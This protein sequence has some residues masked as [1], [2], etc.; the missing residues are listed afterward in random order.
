MFS[1][2]IFFGALVVALETPMNH[3]STNVPSKSTILAKKIFAEHLTQADYENVINYS[4]LPADEK[5][6][7]RQ[8]HEIVIQICAYNADKAKSHPSLPIDKC[9]DDNLMDFI[10]EEEIEQL[11]KSIM[12]ELEIQKKSIKY[13]DLKS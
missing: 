11:K 3:K 7:L 5:K 8:I 6:R 10:T 4:N 9:I 13:F 12:I 1:I 2:C